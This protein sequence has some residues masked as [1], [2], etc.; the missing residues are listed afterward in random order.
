MS[1]GAVSVDSRVVPL[2]PARP[3][4]TYD[5]FVKP[6]LD[7]SV[8]ALALVLLSPLFL[9]L[10]CGVVLAIG[11]GGV[12]YTQLRVGKNGRPFRIFKFRTM[13][14]DRRD[15]RGDFGGPERRTSHKSD[16]D[17]RHTAIGRWMRSLSLDELPQLINVVRGDMSLVGPRPELVSV[18]D[19][20]GYLLH[21]RHLVKPG[22]TG[23]F[24]V[25]EMRSSNS[26]VDGLALDEDYVADVCFTADLK[27]LIL[28]PWAVVSRR[29]S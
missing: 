27:Y 25:S 24:Q 22:M 21:P 10:T 8:A 16:H 14:A 5:L 7:R 12:F 23:P 17:P 19:A 15:D 13:L 3:S 4:S 1:R 6:I 11:P 29:G 28:T 2:A 26:L 9:A 20:G 18:A